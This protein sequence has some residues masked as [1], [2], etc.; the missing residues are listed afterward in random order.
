MALQ[1]HIREITK[2]VILSPSLNNY[3]TNHIRSTVYVSVHSF[4]TRAE[5]SPL[6]QA[7]VSRKEVGLP[8][9]WQYHLSKERAV[10]AAIQ[11]QVTNIRAAIKRKVRNVE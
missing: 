5:D 11:T 2:T 3:T 1:N 6:L 9:D 10:V 7:A 8:C 4:E